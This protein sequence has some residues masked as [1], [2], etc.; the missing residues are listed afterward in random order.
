MIIHV[1]YGS[2]WPADPDENEPEFDLYSWALDGALE[3]DD[4][5]DDE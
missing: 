5:A 3:P 4:E 1:S 2:D